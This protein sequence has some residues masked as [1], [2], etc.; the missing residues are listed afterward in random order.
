MK[1]GFIKYKDA[2]QGKYCDQCG[3]SFY[4]FAHNAKRCSIKCKNKYRARFERSKRN[5][6]VKPPKSLK[7]SICPNI[8]KLPASSNISNICCSV[9]CRDIS[10]RNR[11]NKQK[12]NGNLKRSQKKYS[13]TE[14]SKIRAKKFKKTKKYQDWLGERKSRPEQK[15]ISVLRA[16]INRCCK[17]EKTTSQYI[18]YTI[19]DLKDH[20][21]SKF[22]DGMSWDNYGIRGWH[23]DHIRPISSF[24]FFD[25]SGNV[26]MGEIR[27]CMSLENLQPLWARENIQKG[28]KYKQK[29]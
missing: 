13:K 11:V 1:V 5:S 27:K 25:E 18:D 9:E 7:C 29:G 10:N 24:N 22:K 14:K 15:L 3:A 21:E 26:L 20:I 17:K 2:P 12:D 4:S 19:G 6:I 8:V 28:N 16:T 23:I